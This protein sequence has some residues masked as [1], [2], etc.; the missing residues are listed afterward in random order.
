MPGAGPLGDVACHAAALGEDGRGVAVGRCV[1]DGESLVHILGA[2]DREDRSEDLLARDRHVGADVIEDRGPDVEPALLP[3]HDGVPAVEQD[4]GPSPLR[5]GHVPLDPVLGLPR[6][7]RAEVP[8]RHHRAGVL[9]QPPHDVVGPAHRHHHRRGHAALAGATRHAGDDVAR[10]HL[11]VGIGQHEQVILGAAEGQH[12]LEAGRAP[13]VHRLRHPGRS[14]EGDGG[15]AGMVADRLHHFA[16]AVHHAEDARRQSRLG[17]QLGDPPRAQGHQL[18]RLQ[19]QA[20]AERDRVGQ[21]PV[22]HHA[23]EIE[24]RD[25]RHDPDRMPVGAALHP[26]AHLQHLAGH[27]LR[28]RAGELGQLDRLG[29]LRLGLRA[30]LAVLLADQRGERGEI[31]LQ[32]G[33]VAVEDLDPLLDRL[34]GPGG[35]RALRGANRLVQLG[36][37]GQRHPREPAPAAGVEHVEGRPVGRDEHTADV[38]ADR[39]VLGGGLGGGG[40]HRKSWDCTRSGN[41]CIKYTIR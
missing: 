35:E 19:D 21:G 31:P 7:D 22:R 23:R 12:S 33:A 3:G 34:G 10:C 20:V 16:A 38:V 5:L 13:T 17:Q 8:A 37:R 9:H 28:Q 18:G 26:A 36:W 29:D 27:D 39:G 40:C 25:R 14:D 15:N 6:D 41:D 1:L 2:D 4:R 24:R 11:E 30:R 32:Q